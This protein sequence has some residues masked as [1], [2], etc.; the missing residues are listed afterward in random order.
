MERHIKRRGFVAIC[1][2]FIHT[3]IVVR[4]VVLSADRH[5]VFTVD[6]PVD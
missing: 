1:E 5:V 6:E 2:P 4:V 3:S